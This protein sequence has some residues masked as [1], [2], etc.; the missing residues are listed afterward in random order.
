MGYARLSTKQWTSAFSTTNIY[1]DALA[2]QQLATLLLD[3]AW[4][5]KLRHRADG[6]TITDKDTHRNDLRRASEGM[7]STRGR[8]KPFSLH[9]C[10]YI[11]LT[12]EGE[13]SLS[14][15]TFMLTLDR[16]HE[17]ASDLAEYPNC[18]LTRNG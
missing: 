9:G 3:G 7:Q 10:C 8:L 18:N 12:G 2:Q 11:R 14:G 6:N 16:A 5:A 17:L 4:A 1:A 13:V 15:W